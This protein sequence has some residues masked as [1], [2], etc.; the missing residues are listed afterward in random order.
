MDHALPHFFTR[1]LNLAG[2]QYEAAATKPARRPQLNTPTDLC[3]SNILHPVSAATNS[4]IQT[5]ACSAWP[6]LS[7]SRAR[8][9]NSSCNTLCQWHLSVIVVNLAVA[10][11]TVRKK[12]QLTEAVPIN[13]EFNAFVSG[14]GFSM[15]SE[16]G[17]LRSVSWSESTE[18]LVARVSGWATRG[19][20]LET[21]VSVDVGS[22]T[23]VGWVLLST[24][25][26]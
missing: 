20:P 18:G 13:V 15:L 8:T 12:D 10:V 6:E 5:W 2:R 14:K 22:N 1:R 9:S 7:L 17:V 21:P 26:P 24:L 19:I 11:V 16:G 25:A 4:L 23:A 3:F